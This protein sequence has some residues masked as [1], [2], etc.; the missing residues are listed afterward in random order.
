MIQRGR[1]AAQEQSDLLARQCVIGWGKTHP[2][3][4]EAQAL[5]ARIKAENQPKEY[6]D[7]THSDCK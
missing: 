1:V 5:D 2:I 4:L 6:G 3:T 7:E